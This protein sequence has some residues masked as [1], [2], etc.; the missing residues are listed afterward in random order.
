MKKLVFHSNKQQ[1]IAIAVLA[2]VLIVTVPVVAFGL[3]AYIGNQ[4]RIH[5]PSGAYKEV[6]NVRQVTDRKLFDS[7]TECFARRGLPHR[8]VHGTSVQVQE[9]LFRTSIERCWR[10]L[11]NA[12][13]STHDPEWL[14]TQQFWHG[15]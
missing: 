14:K 4:L 12:K 7:T 3:T 2:P 6:L 5:I 10:E 11:N 1:R 9:S 13:L 15:R 8:V